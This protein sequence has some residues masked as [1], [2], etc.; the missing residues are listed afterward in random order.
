MKLRRIISFVLAAMLMLS[1][2]SIAA[3]AGQAD[4][5][6]TG[7]YN[8]NYLEDYASAAYNETG[9]GAVYTPDRTTFKVWAPEAT[10][11]Q[12]KLYTTGT[13]AESGAAVI[14]TEKMTYNS[15]TGIWSAT[16]EGDHK[17]EYY[18][19][20]V[21]RNNVIAETQDPYATAVGANGNRSMICDLDSTDPDGWDQDQHVFFDNP[22]EAVV[23]EVHVRDF[24]IDVSSGVSD[25][26]KG[27]YLAF[28]EGDTT[29]NGEGAVASCV[30]YLVEHNVNCVQ[31]MPIEDFASIDETDDAVK[32][33]WGY[34]PKNYN[35]PEGSYS[36]DPYN[37][38][39]RITEYK[40]LV[41]AL[42]DR[43]IAV[44]MDV[45]YNH[46]FVLEGSALN[47]TTPN[48]YYRKSDAE[49]F[50]DG[51]GLGN[52]LASEKL[53]VSKYISESLCYWV[54][55]Y[56]IDG[57][58]FDLMGCFDVPNMK[59][60]RQNLDQID[61]R[62]LMYGEPWAG[63]NA[64]IA[65]AIS[66]ANLYQLDRVGAFNQNYSD[67]LKGDHQTNNA[68]E[69]GLG[70][71]NGKDGADYEIKYAASGQASYFELWNDSQ[72]I[73][74]AKVDQLINYTDN[75]DNLTLFDKILASNGTTGYVPGKDGKTSAGA[76]LLTKNKTYVNNPSAQVLG[77]MKIALTSALTSQGIPFTVA[78][79]EFCRTKYGDANSY[80]TPD[81]INAIDWNR[82]ATY[83]NV[84]DYYA[85]LM[86]IRKAFNAFNDR[87]TDA[88][89]AVSGGCTAWQIS[90][91]A[92][93]QW[94]K[95]IVALNNSA[96]AKSI[97]LSGSWTIVANG[98]KAGTVS[99]GTASGSYSVPAWSGVVLVDSASFGSYVQ[100]SPGVA[101][102]TIEHYTRDEATGSY[103]K[104]LTE[105]AKYKEGQTWR[106]SK[107]LAILFD[108]DY[109][110]VESTAAANATYG[111]VTAGDSITVKF[112]YTRNIKSGY[113]TVRFYDTNEDEE[114][115]E[116]ERIKTPMK[117]R[118]RDGDPFSIPATGVQG[119][120]LD[121][122]RYPA[123]TIGTFDADNP[124]TFTFYYKPLENKT[125]RVH[126]YKPGT[127]FANT[128]GTILCYAYD[129]NGNEPLGD[130]ATQ[131]K[132][133]A[134]MK[135]DDSMDEPGWVYI[136]VPTTSCYVMFHYLKLQMPGAGEKGF[137]VSGEA[138]IKNGVV[139]FSNKIV[140]SHI[141]LITGEQIVDDV[142]NEYT[143]VSSNQ[144]Y[145]TKESSAL[146]GT[147]DCI[148]PA[149]ASG[150]YES[151]VTN[152]VYLY[153]EKQDPGPGPD[154]PEPGT[155]WM[156]GDV[157]LDDDV[158]I[159]DATII[160]RY[161][162]GLDQLSDQA[163]LLADVNQNGDVDIVDAT[164][165]QR[166]LAALTAEGSVVGRRTGSKHT[167]DEFLELYGNLSIELS[168]FSSATYGSDPYYM[169]ASGAVSTYLDLAMNPSPDPQEV[170]DAYDACL[171]ALEGLGNIEIVGPVIGG[172]ITLYFTNSKGWDDVYVYYWGTGVSP[173]WPGDKADYVG[174]NTYSQGIYSFT[175]DSGE[176]TGLIFNNGSDSKSADIDV[177]V[178]TQN[179]IYLTDDEAE[180]GGFEYGQ[181]TFNG[182]V[183][184][185]GDNPGGGD[186]DDP[187]YVDPVYTNYKMYF[188]PS[189]EWKQ[190]GARFAAYFFND[191]EGTHTWVGLQ[192]A[193]E[194]LYSVKIPSGFTGIIYCRM[195]GSTI[196]NK[197][198]NKWNQT[199]DLAITPGSTYTLSGWG[200]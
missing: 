131:T 12:I 33:N 134:G 61:T 133:T 78:G 1:V 93:G 143:G 18:T 150:F 14:G 176:Y 46:T 118:L 197:W 104:A 70:F 179:A 36:S 106:A 2:V 89:T 83:S 126:F 48:Y 186:E 91:S 72:L 81:A 20:I 9:L 142:V 128:S 188:S 148:S 13:D 159:V 86:A 163:K 177:E 103:T 17:N 85:G 92:S 3:S 62:I 183:V 173:E 145:R 162:A 198:E 44:V 181:W 28:T 71:L 116:N 124:A 160:Q 94:K 49:N 27:K 144:P 59:I 15:V 22:G 120:E 123:N 158:S 161:L 63:G 55:E 180:E 108:H 74:K 34:D 79:T 24:S 23:W 100:P 35:V 37:G 192:Y 64:G 112:Y 140:T 132:G 156:M 101:S 115:H 60:W 26:N 155:G 189:S 65:N 122:T 4:L 169:A 76:D 56:H 40:M 199:E 96:S 29:V 82:A 138:W 5:A 84:A 171:A 43:G 195:D 200:V 117:Y 6:S 66:N 58:R 151:G 141:D 110:K 119:Y 11:V 190:A 39:T 193:G 50:I 105:T 172:T 99:L 137:T 109:D 191:I 166:Y 175:F 187:G 168:K 152:V 8:Q 136:D 113:L 164:Y 19:Y 57:F 153:T 107:N 130:W 139:S 135:K 51:T 125:T 174:L 95:I 127:K 97:S 69:K 90:N 129:D 167:L 182:E 114:T 87:T 38:N 146:S 149:N 98:T 194:N 121:T 45:V 31:L 73:G 67:T 7:Y 111:D 185:P 53:M 10:S 32:R 184:D 54:N 42:H 170:D 154:V 52:V 77:Q 25:A 68:T 75:H 147:Y 88:I 102:V 47:L 21:N 165:I 80:R 30:D 41:Q 196:E 16:L 157:N 178:L